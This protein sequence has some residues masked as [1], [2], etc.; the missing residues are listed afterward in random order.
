LFL[1]IVYAAPQGSPYADSSLF[2]HI[3]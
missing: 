1:C 3:C 2:E